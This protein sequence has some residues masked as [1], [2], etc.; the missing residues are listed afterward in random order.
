MISSP[1]PTRDHVGRGWDICGSLVPLGLSE[2]PR[3]ENW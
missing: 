2:L 3:R 1:A